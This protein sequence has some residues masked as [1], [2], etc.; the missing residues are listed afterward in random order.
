M[1]FFKRMKYMVDYLVYRDTAASF[2]LILMIRQPDFSSFI[3]GHFS[4]T[5]FGDQEVDFIGV[6]NMTNLFGLKVFIHFTLKLTSKI[7]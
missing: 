6:L 5:C 4:I 1:I 2:G 7:I 3:S